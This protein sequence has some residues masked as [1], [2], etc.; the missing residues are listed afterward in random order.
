MFAILWRLRRHTHQSGWLFGMYC[1]LAG[2]ERFAVEFLRAKSDMIGPVT[3]AQLI[4][5]GITIVGIVLITWRRRPMPEL[6]RAG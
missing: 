1:V 5:L 2:T 3:S 6:A 4:A